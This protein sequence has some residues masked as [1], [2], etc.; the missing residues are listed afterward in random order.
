MEPDIVK[1]FIAAFH[2]EWNK[3]A[4]EREQHRAAKH[5]ELEQ[6]S[7]KLKGLIE[8]IASGLRS[9]SLQE[10]L[11]RLESERKALAA[12]L[13]VSAPT[14]PRFH[15]NLAEL[16]RTKVRNLQ[17]ALADPPIRQEAVETIRGL[18]EAVILHPKDE[19]FEIELIGEIAKMLELPGGPG[20]SVPAM[21]RSSVKVVA[22]AGFVEART[23]LTLQKAI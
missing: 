17:D 7:T 16:Y 23:N 9:D 20:S 22:G 19:G 5:R 13:A 11:D 6:V 12:A 1:E 3:A 18:V 14:L 15:P 4:S 21:Y 10:Q 8:A 2:L